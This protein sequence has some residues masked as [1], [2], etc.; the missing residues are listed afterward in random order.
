MIELIGKTV[1]NFKKLDISEVDS[2]LV[3][4]YLVFAFNGNADIADS[5][6]DLNLINITFDGSKLITLSGNLQQLNI[7]VSAL[8]NDSNK[9]N[10]ELGN[11]FITCFPNIF[12]RNELAL[13][14]RS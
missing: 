14:K 6:R 10:R 12:K 5:I 8:T 3:H 2:K 11:Y 9:L 7:F 13:W 4:E 1:Y